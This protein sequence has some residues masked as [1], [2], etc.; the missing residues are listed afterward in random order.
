MVRRV[1]ALSVVVVL[2]VSLVRQPA[3]FELLEPGVFVPQA[4]AE[5][6]EDKRRDYELME[7]LADALDEIDRNHVYQ[8]GRDQLIEAAIHG[9]VK[10]LNDPHSRF[11]T[12]DEA[13]ESFRRLMQAEY[14]GVG[15]RIEKDGEQIQVV[16]PLVGSPA[17][18]AGIRPGD[19][20]TS[21]EGVTLEGVDV[22][23][24]SRRIEGEEGT[25]IRLTLIDADT[26]RPR[27]VTLTREKIKME[28]VLGVDRDGED[29]WNYLLDEERRIGYIRLTRFNNGCVKEFDKAVAQLLDK[30]VR[31]LV[32]DLRF[33][34][35]G[36]LADTIKVTS[37]FLTEG[38]SIV[39]I[40]GRN[41]LKR[42]N[43]AEKDG[44]LVGIPVVV[45]VNGASGS[46]SE[47]VASCLQD[48]RP[49]TKIVGQRTA[50]K[51]TV[52]N[53]IK[54][55]EGRSL[56]KLTTAAYRR[57]SGKNIHRFPKA[58]IEDDWGVS[59]DEGYFVA[60]S[61]ADTIRLKR[62]LRDTQSTR[63]SQPRKRAAQDAATS[64]EPAVS[65][66]VSITPPDT[67]PSETSPDLEA[68]AVAPEPFVD[69]Q[70]DKALEYLRQQLTAAPAAG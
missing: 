20:I 8:V 44:P 51:G 26:G 35:G 46:G 6:N 2:F 50:G 29:N 43:Y 3:S 7:V 53:I 67:A 42:A 12:G 22:K 36:S 33:N 21:I 14:S 64:P 69:T 24:V 68:E 65:H 47:I 38:T 19:R 23:G 30:N 10:R 4:L 5:E 16:S 49:R 27:Q 41:T 70:L 18:Q 48:E 1:C 25:Q 59:P 55:D 32:F 28:T 17:Y 66:P 11:I 63:K 45:L 54:L 61:K 56:L 60:L 37:R 57:P 34:P 13:M 15:I 58:T 9:M 62:H 52:Q 31:A 40:E 39:T